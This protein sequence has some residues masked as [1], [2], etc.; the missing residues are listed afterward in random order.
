ME[1]KANSP[2][3]SHAVDSVEK[4]ASLA[5]RIRLTTKVVVPFSFSMP[6]SSTESPR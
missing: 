5:A 4:E 1:Y 6:Q 2:L 3:T